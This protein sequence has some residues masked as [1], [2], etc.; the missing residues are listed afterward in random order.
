M[1]SAVKIMNTLWEG[2]NDR[3]REVL[4]G[5]F[6]LDKSGKAQTLA[7]LGER[8]SVT[9]ERIRQIESSGTQALRGKIVS[10]PACQDI[11]EKSR[12]FL[13][14]AGGVAR[15]EDLLEFLGGFTEGFNENHLALLIEATKAFYAYP[16]DR[17]YHSFYYLDK[18]SLKTATS[19]VEQWA[20]FLRNK[21][22]HVLGGRYEDFL[23]EFIK[24]K[25]VKRE[26][27]E[28]YL[29][30][31]HRIHQSPYGDM[32]LSEWPEILPKTIRDRVYLVLKKKRE[33]LHF[34]VI[35]KT[36][37]EISF[38]KSQASAPTVHN[39]LIKDERFV[40][41]G[42]GMY[43]LREH[44]YEPGTAREVIAKI[45]KKH[46]PLKP[47]DVINA[48]QKERF[49]KPNTVLV[50]LQNKGHFQRLENGTYRIRES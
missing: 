44:G 32:G 29:S 18:A 25:G 6:G 36:I 8:Y 16:E 31:T 23:G 33:P 48:V 21:K 1:Y 34:R 41:V 46:G 26:H 12:K 49:F 11:L 37:N 50:N 9:R 19:F 24:K 45:L 17:H 7:A 10:H 47:K 27:A 38:D 39:E 5:R 13:K 20:A 40:L 35:A 3:Q 4:T 22:D 2:L 15:K 43:A 30:V 28:N 14:D 42:R